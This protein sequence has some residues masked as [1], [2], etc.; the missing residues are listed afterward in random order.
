MAKLITLSGLPGAGK[1]TAADILLSLDFYPDAV[2]ISFSDPVR[3]VASAAFGFSRERLN[4]HTQADREWRETPDPFW[5]A[6]LGKPFSPRASLTAVGTD[7]FRAHL[8]DEFWVHRTM[9]K[10]DAAVASGKDVVVT[11]LRHAPEL[12]AI[13][14]L[15]G[16]HA[17]VDWIALEIRRN[18]AENADTHRL[19]AQLNKLNKLTDLGAAGIHPEDRIFA[20]RFHVGADTP[21][22]HPSVWEHMLFSDYLVEVPNNDSID[23]LAFHLREK[24]VNRQ[25]RNI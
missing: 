13:H 8:C 14:Q 15:A 5:S 17:K 21:P 16:T 1:D 7:L 12:L 18:K 11:D 19:R 3:D 22:S 10:I 9:A 6:V 20:A 25:S 24:T 23:A 4:G 2:R